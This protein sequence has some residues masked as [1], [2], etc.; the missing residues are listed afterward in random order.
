MKPKIPDA[1]AIYIKDQ[2]SEYKNLDANTIYQL[3]QKLETQDD[4]SLE[5]A[6]EICLI[7]NLQ[8][9]AF[10]SGPSK[11]DDELVKALSSWYQVVADKIERASGETLYLPCALTADF[12]INICLQLSKP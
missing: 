4:I 9:T 6:N 8:S 5:E 11:C 10:V 3:M 7:E 2:M 1:F 12:T